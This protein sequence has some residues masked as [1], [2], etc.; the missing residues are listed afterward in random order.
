M[1]DSDL[2]NARVARETCADEAIAFHQEIKSLEPENVDE[3]DNAAML[4]N[5]DTKDAVYGV[6]ECLED[7]EGMMFTMDMIEDPVTGDFLGRAE[8]Y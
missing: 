2:E 3:I 1:D 4:S 8:L 5:P 6:L 7:L